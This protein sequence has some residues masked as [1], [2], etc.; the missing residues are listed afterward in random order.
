MAKLVPFVAKGGPVLMAKGGIL[1]M[2]E[3]GI[4]YLTIYSKVVL[5]SCVNLGYIKL[6]FLCGLC[7][8]IDEIGWIVAAKSY[9]LFMSLFDLR[10]CWGQNLGV[11]VGSC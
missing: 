1:P 10:V 6:S 8:S 11:K 7:G 5:C 2:A 4:L 3:I 9:L